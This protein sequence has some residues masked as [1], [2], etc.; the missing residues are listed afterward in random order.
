MDLVGANAV[1]ARQAA[2]L[3]G[4]AL[5]TDEALPGVAG[6]AWRR[7]WAAA[8]DYSV[9]VA[10]PDRP[11]PVVALD[12]S[13]AS[14][15]LCHQQLAPEAARR[16]ERF[17]RYMDDALDA[18]ASAAEKAI[19]EA[20]ATLPLPQFLAA[21]DFGMRLDQLR[22]RYADLADRLAAFQ[23]DN[24]L[25]VIELLGRLDGKPATDFPDS[26]AISPDLKAYAELLTLD[27]DALAGAATSEERARLT[28][29]KAELEDR[30][31]L[32]DH[33]AKLNLRRD[34]LAADAAFARALADLQTQAITKRANELLD[35]H[36]TAKVVD[37]FA[38]ER[39]RFDITHL[40]VGLARK[41][42][43]T[44]AEFDIDPGTRL[45]RLASDIL[46]EGEQRALALA[47]FLTEVALTDGAGP[48]VI[49]DPVSSLDRDRGIKVAER[50]AEEAERRQVIIFTHDLIFFNEMCAQA[51]KRGIDPVTIALFSDQNA[52]GKIDPGGIVWKGSPV[53]K[54]LNR[55]ESDLAPL[56]KVH[57]T[58]PAD[59]EVAIKNL[60]GRLRDTFE[61]VVEEVIF[62][63]IV[64]RGVD[65]VETKKLRL[66]TVPDEL[67][68]R[69]HEGMT[70]ANTYSHDNP[71]AE[72]VEV[73]TPDQCRAHIA[74]LRDLIASFDT[75]QKLAEKGRPQM[76]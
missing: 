41:S 76:K 33:R 50:L 18:A 32:A 62:K 66:I 8:R 24:A 43:Q 17:Q 42:G 26:D 75:A 46:S 12:D 16:F 35:K 13:P 52:A 71:A 65:A 70:R 15:V 45:T 63:D 7:L 36:L 1:A 27:K 31:L 25:R 53:I 9:R 39:E 44:R 19:S 21:P 74:E 20:R 40:K 4:L 61:R 30:E 57:V 64:R 3:A 14:C 49:D 55:L 69:F 72:T 73:P 68:I 51:E 5:F 6:D 37:H 47:G 38:R 22:G 58:S 54:R 23:S 34:L 48:I 11:F 10:Y 29:A 2:D 59:Y 60:Y 56:V 67:A 28:L